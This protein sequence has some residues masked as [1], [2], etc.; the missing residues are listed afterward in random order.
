VPR[1][2]SNSGEKNPLKKRG[3][4]PPQSYLYQQP[5]EGSVS[6]DTALFFTE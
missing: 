6:R 2:P 5:L 4:N 1:N 3:R